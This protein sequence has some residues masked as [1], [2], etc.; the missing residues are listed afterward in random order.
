MTGDEELRHRDQGVKER[1]DAQRDQNDLHD[2]AADLV[3]LWNRT[4]GGHRVEGPLERVPDVDPLGDREAHRAQQE[5][6]RDRHPQLRHA[7]EEEGELPA[8]GQPVAEIAGGGRRAG[9]GHGAGAWTRLRRRT[10]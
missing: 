7:P 3:R 9:L 5:E 8:G 1:T 10:Q 4:D 6:R 2:L